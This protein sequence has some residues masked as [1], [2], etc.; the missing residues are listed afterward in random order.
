M[1]SVS[2]LLVIPLGF[3]LTLVTF[4]GVVVHELAHKRACDLVGVEV[5][6]VRYFRFGNP[7]GYVRH[8][9]PARYR[10]SFLISVAPFVGNTLL[11][12]V[13]L[14]GFAALHTET[15]VLDVDPSHRLAVTWFSGW[16]GLSIGI[17]AFPSTGD[18]NTLWKRSRA[19]WRR[20]PIVLL[21]LPVVAGI[22][23]V[24]LLSRLYLDVLYALGLLVL[25]LALLGGFQ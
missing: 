18:A 8:R 5:L 15:L 23:V 2:A 21:G 1:A 19:E 12:F 9:E 3:L 13:C 4:P 7:A 24:N 6:E 17:H 16:L 11:A 25:A 10:D 20:A 22:Y 14:L